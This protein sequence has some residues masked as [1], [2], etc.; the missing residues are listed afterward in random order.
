MHK[1]LAI[2]IL[3]TVCPRKEEPQLLERITIQ[4]SKGW[5][6]V[7]LKRTQNARYAII[8]KIN[9]QTK[10]WVNNTL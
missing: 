8:I 5:V 7:T 1:H 2:G 6:V 4:P 3:A 10:K 9:P